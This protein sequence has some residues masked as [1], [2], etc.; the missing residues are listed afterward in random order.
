MYDNV[1][2]YGEKAGGG[3][4]EGDAFTRRKACYRREMHD[5]EGRCMVQRRF[6]ERLN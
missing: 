4:R 3:Q 1:G 2:I 6:T 5:T